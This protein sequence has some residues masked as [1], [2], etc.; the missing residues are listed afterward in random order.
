MDSVWIGVLGPLS[1]RVEGQ[2]LTIGSAKQRA[3]LALLALHRDQC[4]PAETLIAQLW[5]VR[6][7]TAGKILQGYVSEAPEGHRSRGAGNVGRGLSVAP[8]SGGPGRS[9]VPVVAQAGGA[10]LRAG[11]PAAARTVHLRLSVCGGES[12]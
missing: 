4:V 3:L 1:V 5:T 9:P 12:A 10:R 6:P 8:G 2:G 7:A 11:D